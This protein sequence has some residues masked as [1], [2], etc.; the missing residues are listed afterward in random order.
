MNGPQTCERAD[1]TPRIVDFWGRIEVFQLRSFFGFS[2]TKLN[3]NNQLKWLEGR[4]FLEKRRRATVSVMGTS[5]RHRLERAANWAEAH[6][7]WLS[8]FQWEQRRQWWSHKRRR[9]EKRWS[10][11]TRSAGLE[12]EA[13]RWLTVCVSP[14]L[15][16]VAQ[17]APVS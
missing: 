6:W 8:A 5:C 12:G 1:E 2:L 15:T 9:P 11:R 7:R 3:T 4:D 16:L 13:R 17:M 10:K 14:R